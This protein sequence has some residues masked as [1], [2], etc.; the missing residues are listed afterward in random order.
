[1]VFWMKTQAGWRE[2]SNTNHLSEDGSMTPKV[3]KRVI[4]RPGD[5]TGVTDSDT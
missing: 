2:T 4:V 1:M 3:I 5:D